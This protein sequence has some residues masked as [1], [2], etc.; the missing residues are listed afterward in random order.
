MAKYCTITFLL[1]LFG[2]FFGLHHFYLGRDK[3]GVLLL[4]S[5]GGF[6]IGWLRDF[7]NLGVYTDEANKKYPVSARRYPKFSS[8]LHRMVA[9]CGFSIFYRFIVTNA[10]PD[11]DYVGGEVYRFLVILIT[12]LGTIFGAYMVCNVGHISCHVKYPVIGAYLG[13]LLFGQLHLMF[14]SPNT[15]LSITV[16]TIAC[17]VG[18]RERMSKTKRTVCKRAAI[19]A[20]LWLIVCGLW[21]SYGYFNAEV[22][23]EDLDENVKLRVI[24]NQFFN[25]DEWAEFRSLLWEAIVLMWRSRGDYE[26][27]WFSIQEGVATSQIREA[28]DTL[29]FEGADVEDVS[30]EELNVAYRRLAKTWHPDKVSIDDKEEAQEM[31]IKIQS[32][33]QLLKKY[34]KRGKTIR[35]EKD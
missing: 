22:Y 9:C 12:P 27:T 21:L 8:N 7:W 1:W 23:I 25:S 6:V 13:E 18:W 5:F 28:M 33:H 19:I 30:E 15:V 24:F 3:H 31:F 20:S 29:G 4:T 34:K 2:G 14:D 32:S 26:R 35:K 11:Q 10:I 17:V 16:C